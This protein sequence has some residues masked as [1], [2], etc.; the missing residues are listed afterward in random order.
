MLKVVVPLAYCLCCGL[1]LM[2]FPEQMESQR[3]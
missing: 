1:G 2:S 3:W